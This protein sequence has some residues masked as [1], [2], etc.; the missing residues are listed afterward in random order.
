MERIFVG[1]DVAKDRLDVHVR[2]TD[3]QFAVAYEEAGVA[4]LVHRLVGLQPTLIVL[5]ATGGYESV[6][7]AALAH[8]GLPV[9]VVNPRQVRQFALATG[10][11][12]KTDRLDARANRAL[13][14]WCSRRRGRWPRAAQV[15][16]LV[17][18]GASSWT[19]RAEQ[20]RLRQARAR[21]CSRASGPT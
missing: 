3:E 21:A 8:A 4:T 2:P 13:R 19:A 15:G 9:A 6:V 7:A 16:N 5:E 1:L 20:N 12:A 17:P 11:L 18:G 10:Q 14:N